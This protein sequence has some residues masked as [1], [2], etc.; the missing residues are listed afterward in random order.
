MINKNK[1]LLRTFVRVFALILVLSMMLVG[2][3][4]EPPKRTFPD[5]NNS[6]NSNNSSKDTIKP[7]NKP[8]NNNNN[9]SNSNNNNNTN[10]NTFD[11]R[12]PFFFSAFE[13]SKAQTHSIGKSD[14]TNQRRSDLPKSHG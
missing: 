3:E 6:N 5:Y 11:I 10:N 2:C 7:N 13:I 8:S 4:E 12:G 14:N 9:N 1:S